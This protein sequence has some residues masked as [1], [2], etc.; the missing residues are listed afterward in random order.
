MTEP[1]RILMPLK[2][3]Q[4]KR[5]F[6]ETPEPS[7]SVKKASD[8]LIFVVQ[9]HEASKL[10]YD[11]RIE[12][13]GVLKSW[14][15]PKGLPEIV[16]EQRLAVL[17]EDH[18]F[19][20]AN[21]QGDIPKGNYG[22]GHVEIWDRGTYTCPNTGSPIEIENAVG[23]GLKNGILHLILNGQK[24]R[25][26]FIFILTGNKSSN[27]KNWLIQKKRRSEKDFS[28]T[29]KKL[30]PFNLMIKDSVSPGAMPEKLPLSIKPMLATPMTSLL[31]HRA[32][33]YTVLPGGLRTTARIGQYSVHLASRQNLS[34]NQRFPTIVHV[35]H[36]LTVQILLDGEI[37]QTPDPIYWVFDILH[38]DGKNLRPLPLLERRRILKGLA[39]FQYSIRLL[40]DQKG[41]FVKW[42][43]LEE[44]SR[45]LLAR[46]EKSPY[47][48]G[49]SAY[50]LGRSLK[51]GLFS[52]GETSQS[53]SKQ[54][55]KLTHLDKVYWHKEKILKKELIEYYR[56]IS[57]VLLP[58]LIDR[59]ESLHRHP[60]GTHQKNFFQKDLQGYHPD[61]VKTI[62]LYSASSKRSLDYLICQNEE[63]LLY[64][65]NLGCIEIN[66]WL[67]K[68]DSLDYPEMVVIDLDPDDIDFK[69]VIEVARLIHQ[70][71]DKISIPHFCKTSG[72]RGLH[73][74][75][76]LQ[77]KYTYNQAREFVL[78][79][80]KI[81]QNQTQ[82]LTSLERSPGKRRKKIYLDCYQNRRGHTI[83]SV[84]SVRPV[85]QACVSTPLLWS[86]VNSRLEPS[87]FTLR[88]V[89]ERISKMGDLWFPVLM[90]A[91]DL[92]L[93]L[94]HLKR[95][96]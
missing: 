80:C 37:T 2:E 82:S 48:P 22:A 94:D 39:I 72:K 41:S 57:S 73:I 55:L 83:A 11:F 52:K 91:A 87:H 10:H 8:L 12:V 35:L 69:L 93:G 50:W 38:L 76:P 23:Q 90:E 84:Y 9:K 1:G 65:A 85:D 62:Q 18:P 29:K 42:V 56:S 64:M 49:P 33:I 15:V 59:P 68:I 46:H 21:F 30:S 74:G 34:F 53:R 27:Q 24:L 14:A 79:V 78:A 96:F 92:S 31:K 36:S 43:H 86:E 17:V 88:T 63:T 67:S 25:G 19:E 47:I 4:K 7:G 89:P 6:P 51:K 20:Y 81:V 77:G 58:H 54:L 40:P 61:F 16:G 45:S 75:I 5:K 26:E 70:I 28:K 44:D 60:N 71:L 66:P 3:Y 32:W 95:Q 13:H